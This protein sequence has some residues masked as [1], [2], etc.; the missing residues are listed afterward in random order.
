MLS[1]ERRYDMKIYCVEQ[2]E[3]NDNTDRYDICKG[4][5][6]VFSEKVEAFR[7]IDDITEID[8]EDG[9]DYAYFIKTFDL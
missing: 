9:Y 5:V 4:V 1:A 6:E 7:F 2:N 8:K 3:Y